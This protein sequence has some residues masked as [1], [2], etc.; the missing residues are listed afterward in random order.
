MLTGVD[1]RIACLRS[2]PHLDWPHIT[3]LLQQTSIAD[4]AP[5]RHA[6]RSCLSSTN[7]QLTVRHRTY[8]G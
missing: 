2:W 8:T 3:L 6:P 4:P 5:N 1:D 7:G